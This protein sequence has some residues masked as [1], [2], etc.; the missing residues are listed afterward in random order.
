MS[1]E[2]IPYVETS[3]HAGQEEKPGTSLGPATV[4]EV[5][6][7]VTGLHD[8]DFQ[9]FRPDFGGPI[10]NSEE[11]LEM[12]G[13]SVHGVNGSVMLTLLITPSTL[14]FSL[15]V[16]VLT[17]NSVTLLGPNQELVGMS[18]LI[19]AEAGSSI[20]LTVFVV[21]VFEDKLISR[22][23]HVSHIPP[24]DSTIGRAGEELVTS[25]GTSEPRDIIDGVVMRFF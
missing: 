13:I 6:V 21:G 8:W 20:S 3:V 12:H 14:D 4:S 5:R 22:S 16:S 24:Q 2:E 1:V 11:I 15:L 18:I 19:I 23:V 9:F 10:S 17:H 25:S 7:V